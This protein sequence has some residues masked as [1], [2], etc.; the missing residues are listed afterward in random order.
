MGSAFSLAPAEWQRSDF[1]AHAPGVT[2][3]ACTAR[4]EAIRK[5]FPTAGIGVDVIVGFPGETAE[6]FAETQRFLADLPVSYLH[7]FPYS[8][9]PGT[10]AASFPDSVPWSER[11]LRSQALRELSQRKRWTFAQAC[12]GQTFYALMETPE[13]GLTENYLRV[14]LRQ[15]GAVGDF[16]PVRLVS[17]G[18]ELEAERID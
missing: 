6:D 2:G 13:E 9:R 8:E 1:G 18:E 15:G 17:V 16:L 11:L 14:Q 3:A 10:P 5:R 12:L 4:I 7:V